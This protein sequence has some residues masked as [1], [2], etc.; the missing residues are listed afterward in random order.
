MIRATT[1]TH[2]FNLPIETSL[3][4]ELLITYS[5]RKTPVIDKQLEDCVLD[6]KTIAVTLTQR[7]TARF[8]DRRPVEIQLRVLTTSDTALAGTIT[9]VDVDRVL[10]D[11]ILGSDPKR[12]PTSII[13][14]DGTAITSCCQFDVEFGE[15]YIIDAGGFPED[16]EGEYGES[17]EPF[18]FIPKVGEKQIIPTAR[19]YV[20]R[21]IV[22]E[23]IPYREVDN[24]SDGKTVTIG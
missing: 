19:K 9:E 14:E 13:G 21:D 12:K 5:Q 15:I 2:I 1:P 22:V 11:D 4:K 10:D 8:S 17:G 7:D 3:I 18:E 6:G 24:T 23:A 20:K 16:Y